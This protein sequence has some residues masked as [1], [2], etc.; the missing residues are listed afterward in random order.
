MKKILFLLGF[1]FLLA[2][3]NNYNEMKEKG[4]IIF[5][6]T[7]DLKS[8]NEFYIDTVGCELWLDQG[9]CQIFKFGNMLVGFCERE[10]TA[11]VGALVTFF[12]ADK[13]DVDAMYNKLKSSDIEKPKDNADYRIYHFYAK[14]P[15]GRPVEFQYFWDEM[16]EF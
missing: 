9:G 12:Y 11:D 13:S 2:C 5:Y 3:S 1:V 7:N 16:K 15:D 6:K 14:D 10:G 4:G 8:L